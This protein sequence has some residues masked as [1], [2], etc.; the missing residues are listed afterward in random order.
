VGIYRSRMKQQT[1]NHFHQ[2]INSIRFSL[3]HQIFMTNA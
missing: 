2:T 3:P 1:E